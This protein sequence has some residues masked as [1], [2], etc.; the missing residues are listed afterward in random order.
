MSKVLSFKKPEKEVNFKEFGR[1]VAEGNLEEAVK[2]LRDILKCDLEQAEKITA[3][4]KS[5]FDESPYVIMQTMQIRTLLEAGRNNDALA[6]IQEV[7]GV[8]GAES[9]QLLHAMN[10]ALQKS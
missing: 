6:T 8:S 5:K 3:N 1:N 10:E 2:V 4:F 9:M 7:F